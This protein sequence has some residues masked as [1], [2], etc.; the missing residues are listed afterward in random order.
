MPSKLFNTMSLCPILCSETPPAQFGHLPIKLLPVSEDLVVQGDEVNQVAQIIRIKPP[1]VWCKITPKKRKPD[2]GLLAGG[3]F[4]PP[5]LPPAV[6]PL[7]NCKFRNLFAE[8][9]SVWAD[10]RPVL[11]SSLAKRKST[12]IS[13]KTLLLDRRISLPVLFARVTMA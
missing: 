6:P 4:R 2:L 8:E 9:R 13:H 12:C 3:Q 7:F 5:R 11:A 10:R 1:N